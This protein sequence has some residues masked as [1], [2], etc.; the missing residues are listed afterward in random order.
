MKYFSS[1]DLRTFQVLD[2]LFK[3]M[4]FL[5][6]VIHSDHL[7]T[8]S[9]KLVSISI[10]EHARKEIRTTSETTTTVIPEVKP[11][12]WIAKIATAIRGKKNNRDNNNNKSRK[13]TILKTRTKHCENFVRLHRVNF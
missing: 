6:L 3:L 12:T 2:I 10:Q 8:M 11:T 7:Y 1:G 13:T 5:T 9:G 4:V